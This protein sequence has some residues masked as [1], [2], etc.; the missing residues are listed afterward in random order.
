[1]SDIHHPQWHATVN[2]QETSILV[3]D[4]ALRAV[5][6]PAGAHTVEMQFQP[7]AWTWGVAVTL[8]TLLFL[9]FIAIWFWRTA[10]R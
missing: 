6:L 9:L 10:D 8:I 1:L 5:Y 4:Y 7:P 3:A 2:G